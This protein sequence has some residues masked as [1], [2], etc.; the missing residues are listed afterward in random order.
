MA[1]EADSYPIWAGIDLGVVF[2]TKIYFYFLH[3]STWPVSLLKSKICGLQGIRKV[4]ENSLDF[5]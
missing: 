2:P 4:L 3:I 1:S 5:S